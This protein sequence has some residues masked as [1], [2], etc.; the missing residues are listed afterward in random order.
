MDVEST[1]VAHRAA[2]QGV[3]PPAPVP[4]LRT[5]HLGAAYSQAPLAP[6]TLTA[7]FRDG[8]LLQT[9]KRHPFLGLLLLHR[10]RIVPYPTQSFR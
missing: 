4:N 7:G 8:D 3:I 6:K 10:A 2:S 9:V 1:S 5:T